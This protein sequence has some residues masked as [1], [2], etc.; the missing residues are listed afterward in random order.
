[1]A[2]EDPAKMF[3]LA[4]DDGQAA[5]R[6]RIEKEKRTQER[7][8]KTRQALR[9][10]CY[11]SGVTAIGSIALHSY[12][13]DVPVLQGL[14]CFSLFV[15]LVSVTI[16]FFMGGIAPQFVRRRLTDREKNLLDD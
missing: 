6:K 9:W 12:G 16:L 2:E 5:F 14:F 10:T 13:A 4:A 8:R 11:I 1:M 7:S 15:A 3:Q